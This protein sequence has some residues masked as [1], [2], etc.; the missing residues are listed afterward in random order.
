MTFSP[1]QHAA[2]SSYLPKK[3]K[4]WFRPGINTFLE[5]QRFNIFFT[6]LSIECL[7]Q[8]LNSQLQ[9]KSHHRQHV[10]EWQQPCFSNFS[11]TKTDHVWVKSRLWP[12]VG[13]ILDLDY[14]VC[15]EQRGDC[16][17]SLPEV[18]LILLSSVAPAWHWTGEKLC[19]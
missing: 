6:L 8:P 4:W 13:S 10:N 15:W 11:F 9:C 1:L 17:T 7:S 19:K 2:A 14:V 16:K 12:I 18:M 5:G 3:R